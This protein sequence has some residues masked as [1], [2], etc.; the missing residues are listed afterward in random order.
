[1]KCKDCKFKTE[2]R[3]SFKKHCKKNG[4]ENILDTEWKCRFCGI[5]VEEKSKRGAH[6]VSC[7]HNPNY[8][9]TREK[10]S[11]ASL[12]RHHTEKTKRKLSK[13]RKKFLSK[14]KTSLWN[15]AHSSKKSNPEM[16]VEN[17]LL[18]R[19]IKGW[20]YNFP[21]GT[22][23][24]DFGFPELKVDIEIDGRQH[25]TES[26]KEHDKIR[27]EWTVSQGWRVLRISASIV[28]KN[29]ETAVDEIV[30]FIGSENLETQKVLNPKDY[31]LL[32]NEEKSEIKKIRKELSLLRLE[33]KKFKIRRTSE[34]EKILKNRL[35][36]MELK[37]GKEEYLLKEEKR[38]NKIEK[39]K[40]KIETIIYEIKH[41]EI[42]F[43]KFGW[44]D[45]IREIIKI[46]P[47][48]VNAWMKKHMSEFYEKNCFKRN[49]TKLERLGIKPIEGI[50]SRKRYVEAKIQI[51]KDKIL[52]SGV[53]FSERHWN[54][55]LSKI[56]GRGTIRHWMKINMSEFYEKNCHIGRKRHSKRKRR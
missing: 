32:S 31:G 42:D 24:Y 21:N 27:D 15:G 5:H 37:T 17:E 53:D 1:M 51:M 26:R 43:S 25:F 33:R 56:V 35:H 19:K 3:S 23:E 38:K 40:L 34:K 8:E 54:R 7:R 2:S 45:K 10:I 48:K 29:V 49:K 39:R 18:R 46:S 55:K 22:Y 12:G 9:K 13:S 47:Q 6:I 44:A 14:N 11:K 50:N 30:K 20:L 36:E 52:S 28:R 41:S 16:I 4:H